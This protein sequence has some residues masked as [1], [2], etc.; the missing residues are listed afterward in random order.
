MVDAF[1]PGDHIIRRRFGVLGLTMGCYVRVG[2]R[3]VGTR[4]PLKE[5][6]RLTVVYGCMYLE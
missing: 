4:G 1:E 5:S 2:V 3:G 6:I